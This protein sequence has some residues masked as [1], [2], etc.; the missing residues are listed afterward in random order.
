MASSGQRYVDT[1]TGAAALLDGAAAPAGYQP[2]QIFV[3]LTAAATTVF[4]VLNDGT[5]KAIGAQ[6]AVV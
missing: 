5:I 2:G 1:Y 6:I 3:D 4:V